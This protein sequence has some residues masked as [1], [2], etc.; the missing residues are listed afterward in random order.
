[1]LEN[2]IENEPKSNK[3]WGTEIYTLSKRRLF[4][5]LLELISTVRANII[6]PTLENPR[7]PSF[8]RTIWQYSKSSPILLHKDGEMDGVNQKSWLKQR[9]V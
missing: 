5:K 4:P 8:W 9:A 3:P 2:D 7:I 6:L 1:M